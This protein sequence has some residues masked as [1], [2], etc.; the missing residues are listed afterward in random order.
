MGYKLRN[1]TCEYEEQTLNL[2]F[3]VFTHFRLQSQVRVLGNIIKKL[4]TFAQ[5]N[6][7]EF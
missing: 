2:I 6:F 3:R 1:T 5:Y 7:T 4:N